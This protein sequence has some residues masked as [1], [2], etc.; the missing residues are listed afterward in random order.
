M[1]YNPLLTDRRQVHFLIKC[2]IKCWC[3]CDAINKQELQGGCIRPNYAVRG[4]FRCWHLTTPRQRQE[5]VLRHFISC[6]FK[7]LL[8]MELTNFSLTSAT[9]HSSI[10]G[11]EEPSGP[12]CWMLFA[13]IFVQY[14]PAVSQSR[15]KQGAK[16]V[17]GSRDTGVREIELWNFISWANAVDELWSSAGYLSKPHCCCLSPGQESDRG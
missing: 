12:L 10:C 8:L 15:L 11:V 3:N 2:C 1:S 16:P 9:R 13:F 5:R 6:M 14:F 7:T 17:T 4:A